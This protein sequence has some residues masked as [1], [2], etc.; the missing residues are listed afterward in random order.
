MRKKIKRYIGYGVLMT[1]ASVFGYDNPIEGGTTETVTNTWSVALPWLMVG[2]NTGSNSLEIIDGGR[3]FNQVG[4]LGNTTNSPYNSALVAGS[5]SLWSNALE[6]SVGY[7]GASNTLAVT[8]GG[9]VVAEDLYIGYNSDGNQVVVAG[10]GSLLDASVLNVGHQGDE[11]SLLVTDGG[12]AQS[13]VGTIGYWIGSDNNTATIQSNGTWSSTTEINVGEYGSG[14]QL[15]VGAGGYVGSPVFNVGVQSLSLNNTVSVDGA[16]AWLDAPELYIGGSSAGAGGS[17][18]L[19]EIQNGG[20]VYT[21][22]LNIFSGNNFDLNDGGRLFINTNFNASMSGFNWN[23]GGT[24]E[25][26]GELTGMN[27]AIEDQRT[28][29]MTGTN[30][31][32]EKPG[33]ALYIGVNTDGNSVWAR[34]GALIKTHELLIGGREYADRNELHVESMGTLECSG[35]LTIGRYGTNN[36]MIIQG[37]GTVNSDHWL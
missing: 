25:V 13:D 1:C 9:T 14:N 29:S 21:E 8:S 15:V 26:G 19:V 4:Y 2:S 35:A 37:G 30:A 22:S 5:G 12:T 20:T 24:L 10:A 18:N 36:A 28:I 11:N 16:E 7:L 32:W 6:L 31:L 33:Y 23:A 17:G 27:A 3:V 34:D